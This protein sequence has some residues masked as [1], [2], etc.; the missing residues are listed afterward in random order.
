[1]NGIKANSLKM[2]REK[3][4]LA[5]YSDAIQ[6]AMLAMEDRCVSSNDGIIE[7]DIEKTIANLGRIGSLGMQETD[8]VI[9]DIMVCK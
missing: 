5:P 6:S 1:M 8:R 3:E 9:L 2:L 7:D 4:Y